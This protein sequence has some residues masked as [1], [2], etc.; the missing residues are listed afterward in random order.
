VTERPQTRFAPGPKGV[1]GYQVW[2]RGA[3]DLLFVPPW[4]WNIEVMWE[5]PRIAR[6]LRRLGGFDRPAL[7]GSMVGSR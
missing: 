1:I 6:F 7:V 4:A 3:L 2:G 5:E